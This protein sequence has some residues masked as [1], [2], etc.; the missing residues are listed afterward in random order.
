M[1][2]LRQKDFGILGDL[3][4]VVTEK[5]LEKKYY[6]PAKGDRDM[7]DYVGRKSM[8]RDKDYE[9]VVSKD[10]KIEN[11]KKDI[12]YLEHCNTLNNRTMDLEKRGYD[13]DKAK[14]KFNHNSK[15]IQ[16]KKRLLK[17]L[18]SS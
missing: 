11:L 12:D 18:E 4:G 14:M 5:S 17:M 8:Y 9:K 1:I 13:Y 3:F 10:K 7:W 15:E 2:I 16:E 6:I